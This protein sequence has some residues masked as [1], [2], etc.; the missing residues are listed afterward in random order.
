MTNRRCS[1][2]QLEAHIISA[3][4]LALLCPSLA[5]ADV[6]HS[7]VASV[8]GSWE[9]RWGLAYEVGWPGGAAEPRMRSRLMLRGQIGV[10]YTLGQF[11]SDEE[12]DPLESPWGV[13]TWAGARLGW[14]GVRAVDGRRV[15][16]GLGALIAPVVT[17]FE[18]WATRLTVAV[19]PGVYLRYNHFTFSFGLSLEVVVATTATG[20]WTN[21]VEPPILLPAADIGIGVAF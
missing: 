14:A 10:A 1:K 15:E 20:P 9:G 12:G 6:T 17:V 3:V 5:Q 2:R 16:L 8:Q 4:A 21:E 19:R 13:T 7:I 18:Q 11:G